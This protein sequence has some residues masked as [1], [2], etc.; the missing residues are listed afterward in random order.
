VEEDQQEVQ[1]RLSEL[2]NIRILLEEAWF[3]AREIGGP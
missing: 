1:A 2:E 3:H